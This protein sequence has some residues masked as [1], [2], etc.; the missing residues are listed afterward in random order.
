MLLPAPGDYTAL[1]VSNGQILF[2]SGQSA[3]AVEC[4]NLKVID[5]NVIEI[6]EES[7]MFTISADDPAVTTIT[8]STATIAIRE[9]DNDGK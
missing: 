8:A 1:G 5:D 6:D 7:L 2:T 3:G 9:N 4:I